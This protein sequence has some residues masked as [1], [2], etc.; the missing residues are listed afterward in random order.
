MH[1]AA[2]ERSDAPVQHTLTKSLLL[3]LLPGAVG[4]VLSSAFATMGVGTAIPALFRLLLC[5]T[6]ILLIFELGHLALLGYHRNGRL[7]LEG[8]VLY[9]TPL[10][11][12]QLLLSVV[13]LTLL[14]M[15]TLTL[16]A[17]LD[18]LLMKR[19][20]GWL[21]PWFFY[22]DLTQYR[23]FDRTT[24]IQL[25]TLRLLLDGFALPIIEELYF[26]GYLLPRVE[27]LGKMA[28]VWNHILFSL[29]HFWQPY[30]LPTIL[31]LFPMTWAAWKHRSLSIS[32]WTHITLNVIG[33][34]LFS[35]MVL[36][37][38]R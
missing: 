35:M 26:R 31:T 13:S 33:S 36:G 16:T 27:R 24:L 17:P 5:L 1:S 3:H 6:F 22:G 9:R 18:L 10:P 8:I 23:H 29:Y 12:K 32:L 11:Q 7:S 37:G 15:L 14:A 21:P 28:P 19:V 30:N 25:C 2:S 34:I 4:V 38:S 20:F